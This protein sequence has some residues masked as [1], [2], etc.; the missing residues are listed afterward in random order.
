MLVAA[1]LSLVYPVFP[2]PAMEVMMPETALILRI[3]LLKSLKYTLLDESTVMPIGLKMPALVAGPPSPANVELPV[4]AIVVM[5][6]VLST[7]LRTTLFR[8]SAMYK[9]CSA[10]SIPTP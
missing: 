5:I 6:L 3:L 10:E 8:V 1:T 2:F 4:P 9:Y 7:T